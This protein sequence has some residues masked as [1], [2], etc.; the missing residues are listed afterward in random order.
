M[1]MQIED[2]WRAVS[3]RDHRADGSFVFAVQ[4][5]GIY[6]RP[7]CP[8]RRPRREQVRFFL[9]AN[10]AEQ[11]GFRACRRCRPETL[12]NGEETGNGSYAE[13]IERTCRYINDH[14]DDDVTLKRLSKEI[15]MSV[16]HLQRLFRQALGVTPRQY[17]EVRRLEQFK[18]RLREGET[19]TTARY[20]AGYRS[21]CR[22]Y[23][24][25]HEKI[26]MTPTHYRRGGEGMHITYTIVACSLGHLLVGATER[27]ICIVSLNDDDAT[28]E[29]IL[30]Q[31]Y[32]AADLTHD[33]SSLT[34]S[35]EEILSYLEKKDQ[36]Q[37]ILRLP[38]DVYATAFQW[39]VWQVLRTIPY[40][41]T[42]SYGEIAHDLGDKKKARAVAQACARNPVA[43]I[44]PCHRVVRGDGVS[45]GYRW[46]ADRKRHLLTMEQ[47]VQEPGE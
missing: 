19:V 2:Y 29:N 27:G 7:S 18:S 32:P 44:V 16:F 30:H 28:L 5:T 9:N 22:L 23:D 42:R 15:G 14:L 21:S 20:E 13:L 3:E 4:S 25:I 45:G 11:A 8:A 33:V 24:H 39:R 17:T 31:E 38:L 36:G 34:E 6:C 12:V 26:G 1:Q 46:G 47:R 37:K 41:E 40:G 43:L 35:V 10:D